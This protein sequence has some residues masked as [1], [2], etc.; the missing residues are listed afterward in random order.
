MQTEGA[1]QGD[2]KGDRICAET[3]A[4]VAEI[5]AVPGVLETWGTLM[6]P[7]SFVTPLEALSVPRV[8]GRPRPLTDFSRTGALPVES[9]VQELAL[10]ASFDDGTVGGLARDAVSAGID[11]SDRSTL[12]FPI[13]PLRRAVRRSIYRRVLMD[14]L[15]RYE[16]QQLI[17]E[18]LVIRVLKQMA[19]DRDVPE[20]RH[21]VDRIGAIGLQDAA[22]DDGFDR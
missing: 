21:L 1:R 2:H 18:V 5:S 4:P 8:G 3:P 19:E 16:H 9:A 17:F 12:K 22:E 11:Q 6:L 15:R 20:P 14:D 13:R 10:R 7:P